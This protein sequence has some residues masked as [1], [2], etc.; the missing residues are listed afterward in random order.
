[1]LPTAYLEK[2]D[3]NVIIFDWSRTSYKPY[4]WASRRVVPIALEIARMID[5]LVD[6]G[7]LDPDT[8][9]LVGHSLGAHVIGLAGY[10]SKH[11]MRH[12]IGKINF[13]TNSPDENELQKKILN[14][15]GDFFFL[16]LDP[17]L[18]MFR[19]SGPDSSISNLDGQHVQIIHTNGGFLGYLGAAG[20]TDFYPNG[21]S[22]QPGCTANVILACACSHGRAMEYYAESIRTSRP[23][24]GWKCDSFVNFAS[25]NCKSQNIAPM[26]GAQ[27]VD[28][29]TGKYYLW[30]DSRAPFAPIQ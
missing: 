26:G 18:P 6:Y 16:G 29:P 5:F 24:Y 17:A 12:V 13:P 11:M 22:K 20:H 30:T 27:P 15:R 9:T 4:I 1:M 7:Q 2:N 21:G 19:F 8:T 3:C 14:Y 10:Y 28:A 25:G 23:F